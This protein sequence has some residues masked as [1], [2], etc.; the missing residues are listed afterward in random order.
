MALKRVAGRRDGSRAVKVAYDDGEQHWAELVSALRR[1]C[2]YV[3]RRD[4]SKVVKVAYDD[5]E[6]HWAELVRGRWQCRW[7]Y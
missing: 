4:G 7:I 6:Q 3:G 1:R 2:R 5:G